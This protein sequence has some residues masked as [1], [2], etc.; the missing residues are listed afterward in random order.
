MKRK[1][2]ILWMVLLILTSCGDMFV[3]EIEY[4]GDREPEMLSLIADLSINEHPYLYA[5]HS[6]FIGN[7]VANR[8]SMVS[9]DVDAS[10]RINGG[11]WMAMT[12]DD[13]VGAYTQAAV[14][15]PHDTVEIVA[16]HASYPMATA[17][18]VM[19]GV[20]SAS[21][22]SYEVLPNYWVEVTLEFDAYLGN[23][24]DMIA[25]LLLD[26]ASLSSSTNYDDAYFPLTNIYSTDPVFADAQNP[27]MAGYYGVEK[28][29]YLFF[30]ASAL[31]QKRQIRFIIDRPWSTYE[32]EHTT[33]V[34]LYRLNLLVVATT[35]AVYRFDR[36]SLLAAHD[37]S[38]SAPSGLPESEE[39]I[40]DEVIDA[41]KETLG[42]QEPVHVYS[43]IEGGVGHIGG[44]SGTYLQ[45][46]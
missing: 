18:Q 45:V 37:F 7:G 40:I 31:Q 2:Y 21:V 1:Y 44:Y 29:T 14:L 39:S 32:R 9:V 34:S 16:S 22:V 38:V 27:E 17:R 6:H 46:K 30:P 13:T 19:P 33:N 11:P 10:I 12:M 3:R 28:N 26:E 4:N 5:G 20:L 8:D 42:E 36:T 35:Y 24:D 43:N 41:I 23:P 25:V 15:Q